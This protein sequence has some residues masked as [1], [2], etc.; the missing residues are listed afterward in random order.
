MKYNQYS[1]SRDQRFFFAP[2]IH[3]RR[4]KYYLFIW[5]SFAVIAR[6]NEFLIYKETFL[7]NVMSLFLTFFLIRKI[8]HV[9]RAPYI[10][11]H[12]CRTCRTN[13]RNPTSKRCQRA[14]VGG[15]NVTSIGRFHFSFFENFNVLLVPQIHRKPMKVDRRYGLMSNQEIIT[16]NRAITNEK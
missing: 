2:F 16:I 8:I 11:T 12:V 13:K 9:V 7:L 5:C 4:F 1:L 15:P 10:L 14:H 6:K 3:K